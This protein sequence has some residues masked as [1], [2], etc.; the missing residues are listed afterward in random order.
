MK[1]VIL[2]A[3][4]PSDIDIIYRWENDPSIWE[5][6][7]T[8]LPF[9]RHLLTQYLMENTDNDIYVSKQLRLVAEDADSHT[10]VGCVD[11]F[12]FDPY[13]RRAGLGLLVDS[14]LRGQGYGQATLNALVPFC[15]ERLQLHQLH[16]IVSTHNTASLHTFQQCGFQPHGTLPHWLHTPQG[17]VDAVF[18]SLILE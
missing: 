9:S 3:L 4:E 11:L 1:Q 10:T 15:H 17:W 8:H 5:H 2:R 7:V 18:L 12:D 6:S 16:C 14:R 13:H